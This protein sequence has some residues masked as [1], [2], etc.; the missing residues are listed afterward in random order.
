MGMIFEMFGNEMLKKVIGFIIDNT[1]KHLTKGD[2]SSGEEKLTAQFIECMESALSKTCADH[3]MEYLEGSIRTAVEELTK[4]LNGIN[5]SITMK[6]IL[7]KAIGEESINKGVVDTWLK[8]F[9]YYL[10]CNQELYNYIVLNYNC[11]K[12]KTKHTISVDNETYIKSFYYP[13]FLESILDDECIAT[14][15]QVYIKPKCKLDGKKYDLYDMVLAFLDKHNT[16]DMYDK[17][18]EYKAMMILGKPG[19]GKSSFISFLSTHLSGEFDDKKVYIIRLRD[20]LEQQI[21][22]E[23]PIYG[24]LDYMNVTKIELHDAVLILDGL[25]EICAIYKNT[26]FYIYLAK[27]LHNSQKIENLKVILTSRTG[28][29]NIDKKIAKFCFFATI[30][31]WDN[32]DLE[33][34]SNKYSEIHTSLETV[35]DKNKKHLMEVRYSDKKAIFAVPILFYMANARGELLYKHSSICSIYDAVLN[36]VSEK[37]NYDSSVFHYN[38]ELITSSMARQI[39]K[40]IAFMMFKNGRLSIIDDPY[41]RPDEVSEAIIKATNNKSTS[42]IK[43]TKENKERI[44]NYYALSFYYNNKKESDVNAVEFAHRTIAEYFVAEKII[45]IL[46]N[47]VDKKEDIVKTFTKCFGQAP[48]TNDIMV[49]IFEKINDIQN[50]EL[51]ESL[52]KIKREMEKNLINFVVSGKLYSYWQIEN[53]PLHYLDYAKVMTVSTL[54]I[55]E[56]LNCQ[57]DEYIYTG[58]EGFSNVIATLARSSAINP[59]HNILLPFSLNGL[60]LLN[61][62]FTYCDLCGAHLSGSNLTQCNF[63]RAELV[64]AHM[65]KC[66]ISNAEFVNANLSGAELTNITESD[67]ADFTNA[68]LSGAD[69]SCS[70]FK[71]TSFDSADLF[72]ADLTNCSF[73]ENC[74]FDGA[75]LYFTDISN[76]NISRVDLSEAIFD[77]DYEESALENLEWFESEGGNDELILYNVT[78]TKEQYEQLSSVRYIRLE[79]AVIIN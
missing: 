62:N 78:L 31:N 36:E 55:C 41:L 61:S 56:Y 77:V 28:Y 29:F 43:L 65:H 6:L 10:V 76:S 32:S 21:N 52:K 20:M 40:E 14:L 39:C 33:E 46:K 68:V 44:K 9:K 72:E 74:S 70:R 73:D 25:D 35:I 4:E 49:F 57:Y 24:I 75:R 63:T 51:V 64:D 42:K 1:Y 69:L 5:S 17:L 47:D 8:H 26:D 12:D 13:L 67:G 50:I 15:D 58:N 59:Q 7:V 30:E 53:S 19:S 71:N 54:L 2:Y 27:L 16:H 66:V 34:W 22:S 48:L 45:E 23:D 11:S 18:K 60:N 38:S 37:R 79:D 3:K